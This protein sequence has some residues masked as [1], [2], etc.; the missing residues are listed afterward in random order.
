MASSP[1]YA[2]T[3]IIW[4]ARISVAN[5]N[6][7]GTGAVT[8]LGT[9]GANGTRIDSVS[10]KALQATT[11]G[12]IRFYIFDGTNTRFFSEDEVN[13]VAATG[14]DKTHESY[15]EFGGGLVLPVNHQLRVSTQTGE[16]FDVMAYGGN[17]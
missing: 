12:M 5:T 15:I 2:A 1:Q 6:R 11:Q 8:T 13:P 3:P 17:L 7:D 14:L 9:S 10:I 4:S 16:V